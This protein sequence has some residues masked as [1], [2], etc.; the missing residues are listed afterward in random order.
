MYYAHRR[1]H[2]SSS[3]LGMVPRQSCRSLGVLTFI[4]FTG[5]APQSQLYR[6]TQHLQCSAC[7]TA[8][9]S[10]SGSPRA[11]EGCGHRPVTVRERLKG[12][13]RNG[14]VLLKDQA[15]FSVPCIESLAVGV[16]CWQL[17]EVRRWRVNICVRSESASRW[18]AGCS[19]SAKQAGQ[20]TDFLKRKPL[21]RQS[22]ASRAWM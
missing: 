2:A 19:S 11:V 14:L 21:H 6:G 9:S 15:I 3:V 22:K 5:E 10:G 12:K 20:L 7:Y 18:L 16:I 13:T 4:T 8:D 1:S 17:T